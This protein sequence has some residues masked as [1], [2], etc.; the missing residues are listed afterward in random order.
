MAQI[1]AHTDTFRVTQKLLASML[2]LR[3]VGVTKTA[4]S[5]LKRVLVRCPRGDITA[6]DRRGLRVSACG[7]YSRPAAGRARPKPGACGMER[8]E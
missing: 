3:Q 8:K 1:R 5:L 4:S 7:C 2:G 6:L